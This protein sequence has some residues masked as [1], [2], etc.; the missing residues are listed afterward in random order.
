MA[1]KTIAVAGIRDNLSYAFPVK[2]LERAKYPIG[3]R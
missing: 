1:F 2:T 3:N